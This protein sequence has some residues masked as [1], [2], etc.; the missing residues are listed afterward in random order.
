MALRLDI[1]RQQSGLP[2]SNGHLYVVAIAIYVA[3]H[4]IRHCQEIDLR[5]I[6]SPFLWN[7][8]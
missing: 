3:A 2:L 1:W 7:N 6:N 4:I 8:R 5:M